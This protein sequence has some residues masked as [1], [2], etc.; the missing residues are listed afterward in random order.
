MA[1]KAA[2]I[3]KAQ[4]QNVTAAFAK[5]LRQFDSLKISLASLEV[6]KNLDY[7]ANYMHKKCKD[8]KQF[9]SKYKIARL[10]DSSTPVI[11][12]ADANLTGQG[13]AKNYRGKES[14]LG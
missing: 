4:P 12:A 9:T 14:A 5:L 8:T 6:F 1:A 13:E 2:E 10:A 7:F 11:V 3:Q